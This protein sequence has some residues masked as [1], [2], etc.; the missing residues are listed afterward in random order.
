[1]RLRSFLVLVPCALLASGCAVHVGTTVA[2]APAA[3]TLA[4]AVA[5]APPTAVRL[6]SAAPAPAPVMVSGTVREAVANDYLRVSYFDSTKVDP[7]KAVTTLG[8][9]GAKRAFLTA[10]PMYTPPLKLGDLPAYSGLVN[11]DGQELVAMRCRPANPADVDAVLA[12]WPNVFAAIGRDV[13][14]QPGACDG[15]PTDA[16]TQMACY[17]QGFKDT[18]QAAVPTALGNTFSYAAVLYDANHATLA[19]WLHDN[20][21]IFAAFS[22]LGYSVKDSYY[23]D[24]QHPMS[25]QQILVESISPEYVL[26][27]VTLGVAGCRCIAVPSYP[28]RSGDVLDPDFIEQQGG[29]G[30]CVE[31]K[32]LAPAQ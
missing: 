14:L 7:T 5:A 20:Y 12:T 4:P 30:K 15:N 25:S 21:G 32:A 18:A 8:R 23:L 9:P 26:K 27:N 31:V 13:A 19:K 6:A 24:A 28:G 29:D 17:A 2:P 11:V 22:G 1:M 3:A 16:D 10:T